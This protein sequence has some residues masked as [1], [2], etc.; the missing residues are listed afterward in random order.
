MLLKSDTMSYMIT[1]IKWNVNYLECALLVSLLSP[2]SN[3]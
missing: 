2:G 1:L 3:F